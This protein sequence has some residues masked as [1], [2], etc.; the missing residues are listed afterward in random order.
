MKKNEIKEESY[1]R[2]TQH[3]FLLWRQLGELF[4]GGLSAK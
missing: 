2:Q 1:L 3:I 4:R